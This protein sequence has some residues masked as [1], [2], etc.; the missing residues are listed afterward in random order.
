[1]KYFNAFELSNTN[2]RLIYKHI[3]VVVS[4]IF[5]IL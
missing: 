5:R 4:D 2:A 1:M 3:I